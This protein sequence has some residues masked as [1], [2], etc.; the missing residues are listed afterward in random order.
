MAISMSGG[1]Y[2]RRLVGAAA[3]DASTYEEVEGDA[4]ATNQAFATVILSGLA[5]GIGT[6]GLGGRTLTSVAFVSTIALLTW[7]IWA[8]IIFEIGVRLMPQPQTRS[9]VGEL[10][11]TL[12]FATAPGCAL[13]LGAV[14]F[15]T[16]PVFTLTAAW[17]LSA[18]VVAVRQALDFDSTARAIAVC[19]LGWAIVLGIVL[20]IGLVFGPSLT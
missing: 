14:P 15:M 9:G 10:L 2:L 17:M 16:I 8:V 4:M 19:S 18:T 13:A 7:A 12:G 3:L 11:R 6:L 1:T 5:A 20:S